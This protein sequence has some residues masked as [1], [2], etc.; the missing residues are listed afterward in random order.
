MRTSPLPAV[1]A[2]WSRLLQPGLRLLGRQPLQ[3][4][5]ALCGGLV[6]LPV[7]ALLGLVLAQAATEWSALRAA[8]QGNQVLGAVLHVDDAARHL[9]GL[10]QRSAAGEGGLAGHIDTGRDRLQQALAAMDGQVQALTAFDMAAL[11]APQRE[12]LRGL[13]GAAP[14]PA[15]TAL[16]DGLATLAALVAERSGLVL[17]RHADELDLALLGTHNLQHWL[18]AVD[19]LRGLGAAQLA[20]GGGTAA[21]RARLLGQAREVERQLQAGKARLEALVRAGGSSP[22]RW[23]STQ[24][25]T[26]RFTAL[27]QEVFGA[28]ASSVGP[29]AFFA[30]GSQAL[31]E[32]LRLDAELRSQLDEALALRASAQLRSAGLLLACSLLA[33]GMLAG[34]GLVMLRNVQ[35]VLAVLRQ[36]MDAVARGDLAH[37]LAL[38]GDDELTD[39]GHRVDR[40]SEHLSIAGGRGA[41]QRGARG[42]GRPERGRRRPGAGQ[43]HRAAGAQPDRIGAVGCSA[44]RP[45]PSAMPMPPA[46]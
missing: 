45:V 3:T 8:R 46:P 4:K 5:L 16:T 20:L 1:L 19:Q 6:L 11:W 29:P 21:E 32:L 36:G 39:L 38:S 26:N 44:W 18:Q 41:Q 33:M 22:A 9:A 24:A 43:P 15:G 17:H 10:R 37:Q 2:T 40:M 35:Q 23:P 13:A 27:T 7:L 30:A 31:T 12:R 25:A 28:E 42:P 14:P 34:L